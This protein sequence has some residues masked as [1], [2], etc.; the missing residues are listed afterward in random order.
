MQDNMEIPQ[1]T[2]PDSTPASTALREWL[3]RYR[4]SREDF[5]THLSL[6]GK[7]HGIKTP[8][9]GCS[10]TAYLNG[11]QKPNVEVAALIALATNNE[12]MADGWVNLKRGK[13]EA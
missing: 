10:I 5:I 13:E 9:R 2:P 4:M 1:I 11:T 3:A 8:T 12:V 7:V 6:Y